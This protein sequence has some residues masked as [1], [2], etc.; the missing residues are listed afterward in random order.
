LS[1]RPPYDWE[2]VLDFFQRHAIDGIESVAAGCYRRHIQVDGEPGQIR[3]SRHPRKPALELELDLPT[4]DRLMLVVAGVRRMFD[5]DANPAEINACLGQSPLLKT[6]AANCPGVRSPT[7]WSLFE[8][9]VRSVVGQ[10]VSIAAARGVCAR[11][12]NA[13]RPEAN[14]AALTFPEPSQLLLLPDTALPMPASRKRTL[15]AVCRYFSAPPGDAEPDPRAALLELPG[16]GPWTVAMLGMRGLGDPD[17]FPMGDL[18]LLKAARKAGNRDDLDQR[19][20]VALM[21]KCKP[22][23]SYAANLLWRSLAQ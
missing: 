22:W 15:R 2:G 16:I 19:E 10:Q 11:L 4:P 12:A 1:Y 21:E 20:L 3:V 14:Q 17:V 23:R 8:S 18:G 9:S 7:H 13:C 5:L 6:L